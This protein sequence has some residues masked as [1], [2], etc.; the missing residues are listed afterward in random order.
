MTSIENTKSM[1]NAVNGGEAEIW[2]QAWVKK[3]K[4]RKVKKIEYGFGFAV[5]DV[6]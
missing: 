2:R 1:R 6:G 3:K 5:D 4:K